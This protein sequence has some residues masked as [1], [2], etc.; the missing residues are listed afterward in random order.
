LFVGKARVDYHQHNLW[1]KNKAVASETLEVI[2]DGYKVAELQVK[3]LKERGIRE[4]GSLPAEECCGALIAMEGGRLLNRRPD[5]FF[6]DGLCT[7]QMLVDTPA[8]LI[9]HLTSQGQLAQHVGNI[10]R[11]LEACSDVKFI[12][13]RQVRDLVTLIG[14][15]HS[16]GSGKNTMIEAIGGFSVA[17]VQ[18]HVAVVTDPSKT[19]LDVQRWTSVQLR[20]DDIVI[21]P[22][23]L[24][25]AI[26]RTIVQHTFNSKV[27]ELRALRARPPPRP[28]P[29]SRIEGGSASSSSTALVP[30]ATADEYKGHEEEGGD[31]PGSRSGSCKRK[32]QASHTHEE[33][34][35]TPSKQPRLA[36]KGMSKVAVAKAHATWVEK[37]EA[38]KC[39]AEHCIA[40]LKALMNKY[41]P[42]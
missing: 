37:Y 40:K 10:V 31:T 21:G 23:K 7:Q 13:E 29:R 22:Y 5:A 1:S 20:G 41:H 42:I 17:L 8:R 26:F 9:N 25:G 39:S 15:T 14:Q 3:Q 27:E 18:L 38:G 24:L 11:G 36:A 12:S 34:A 32:Q 30:L 35:A 16:S 28:P 4:M 19:Q 33:E 2:C 6:T